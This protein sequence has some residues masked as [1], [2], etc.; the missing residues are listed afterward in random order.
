MQGYNML[1]NKYE[2][3]GGQFSLESARM[4][5]PMETISSIGEKR[6][7]PDSGYATLEQNKAPLGMWDAFGSE[8]SKYGYNDAKDMFL[9]PTVSNGGLPSI[10]R[11]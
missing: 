7:I 10:P 2:G 1:K 9:D 6:K 5:N 3:A 4:V 8:I 11:P